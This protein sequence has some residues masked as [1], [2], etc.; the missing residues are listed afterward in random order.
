[1]NVTAIVQK[2]NVHYYLH[3]PTIHIT[4]FLYFEYTIPPVYF[5][6]LFTFTPAD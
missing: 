6:S 5:I 3:L 4:I 2:Y 1:M